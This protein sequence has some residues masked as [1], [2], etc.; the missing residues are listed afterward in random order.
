M[1]HDDDGEF[2]DHIS[3][4][5]D[6]VWIIFLCL[7]S[8]LFTSASFIIPSMAALKADDFV[9]DVY[10]SGKTM[11]N[12]APTY[13]FDSSKAGEMKRLDEQHYSFMELMRDRLVHAPVERPRRILDM[14]CGTGITTITI[15]RKFPEAEVIGKTVLVECSRLHTYCAVRAGVLP[16]NEPKESVVVAASFF[17]S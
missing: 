8:T 4:H 5:C 14:C 7:I 12:D 15:A 10:A 9:K 1:V 13:A 2:S 3:S 17:A 6:V 16:Y 11:R